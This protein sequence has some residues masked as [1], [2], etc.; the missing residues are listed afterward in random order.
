FNSSIYAALFSP[1][2]IHAAVIADNFIPIIG[3]PKYKINKKTSIGVPRINEI[4]IRAG[5]RNIISFDLRHNAKNKPM[6]IPKT[7]LTIVTMS[8]ERSEERRVGT[9]ERSE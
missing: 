3:K 2:P 4:Y 1:K 5:H 9:K 8:I 6:I 7:I